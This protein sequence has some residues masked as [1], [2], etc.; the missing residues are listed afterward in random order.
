MCC[1]GDFEIKFIH[2]IMGYDPVN[3]LYLHARSAH[4]IIKIQFTDYQVSSSVKL[5]ISSLYVWGG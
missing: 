1:H 3:N 2:G 5:I 4:Q